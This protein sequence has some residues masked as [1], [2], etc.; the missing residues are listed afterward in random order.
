MIDNAAR[1]VVLVTKVHDGDTFRAIVNLWPKADPTPMAQVSI[2]VEG[3]NAAELREEEGPIMRD[4][5]AQMLTWGQTIDVQAVAMSF[6]RVVC[7]V[8]I[9]D[10]LFAGVLHGTLA[11]IRGTMS[12]PLSIPNLPA[13]FVRE[14]GVQMNAPPPDL[15][16]PIQ[17]AIQDSIKAANFEPGQSTVVT[18]IATNKGVNTAV[19]HRFADGKIDIDGAFWFGKEWGEPISVGIAGQIKF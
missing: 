19:V 9:D 3:W 17:K 14:K 11:A 16:G 15:L 12:Q 10:V 13:E 18:W 8:W 4:L 2:R 5:F 7:K 1:R 6:Q